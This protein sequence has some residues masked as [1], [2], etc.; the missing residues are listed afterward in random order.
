M[1]GWKMTFGGAATASARDLKEVIAIHIT[2]IKTIIAISTDTM[3]L[4][5]RENI[6]FVV[7][8]STRDAKLICFLFEVAIN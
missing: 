8:L 5:L 3:A 2:G 6:D 4:R 7:T 1:L